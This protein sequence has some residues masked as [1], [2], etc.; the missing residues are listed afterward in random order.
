MG[1][2]T[3]N[4]EVLANEWGASEWGKNYSFAPIRLPIRFGLPGKAP[5][6]WRT[7]RRWRADG[8]PRQRVS[9][10][11]CGGPPA[12]SRTSTHAE[13]MTTER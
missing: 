10:L 8:R 4:R 11:E 1:F 12:L 13:L 6:A 2:G 5:E 7:P 3:V 9:V